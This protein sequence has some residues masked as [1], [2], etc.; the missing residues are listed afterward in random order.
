MTAKAFP[1]LAKA[2]PIL[3]EAL[4]VFGVTSSLLDGGIST[5][6]VD[7]SGQKERLIT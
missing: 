2:F 4:C 5:N 7:D 3:A 1:I 6:V